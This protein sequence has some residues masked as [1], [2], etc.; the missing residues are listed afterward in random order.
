[1]SSN[2]VSATL[3]VD[4]MAFDVPAKVLTKIDDFWRCSVPACS[5]LYWEGDRL[6]ETRHAFWN[7]FDETTTAANP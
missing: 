7:L 5:K 6:A 4:P 2:E 3:A 1:M